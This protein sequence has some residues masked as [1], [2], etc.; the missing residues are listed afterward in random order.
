MSFVPETVSVPLYRAGPAHCRRPPRR[1]RR[2]DEPGL[3]PRDL[4]E[5]VLVV[6]VQPAAGAVPAE[7][8]GALLH[9][10]P[11][12]AE[13]RL[14]VRGEGRVR[15]ALE[16]HAHHIR[17]LRRGPER[18]YLFRSPFIFLSLPRSIE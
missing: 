9:D 12:E 5:P 6:L 8:E 3:A 11:E 16:V 10:R 2:R 7:G 4:R 14:Q 17:E 18:P 1:V 15:E 13:V